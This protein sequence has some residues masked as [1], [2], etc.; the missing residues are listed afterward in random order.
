M[1][2][3]GSVTINSTDPLEPPLINP[4]YFSHQQDVTTMQYAITSAQ[5][6]LTAPVWED[7]ILGIATNTTED[8]IRDG[9]MSI[10]H[11]IGTASI[12]P[13]GAD[14]GVVDPDL[15]LKGADGVRVVDA[16][17]LVSSFGWVS[18]RTRLKVFLPQPFLP[19]AHTQ[20]VVYAIAERAADLIRAGYL[21][22]VKLQR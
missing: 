16:S 14:W 21:L 4:N 18:S 6:F 7:Y 12:S 20:V 2:T 13:P 8:D 9:V 15:K 5:K 11:P 22:R 19:A 10:Y 1:I 3:G 17:V